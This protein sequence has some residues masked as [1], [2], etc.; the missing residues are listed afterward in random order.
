MGRCARQVVK[1]RRK[2]L[3]L[4]YSLLSGITVL[5]YEIIWARQ[6]ALVFGSTI[7]ATAIIIACF[8]AGIGLGSLYFGKKADKAVRSNRLLSN[9]QISI[10][11]F[12]LVSFLIFKYLFSI[13][14]FL[15]RVLPGNDAGYI[16]SILIALLCVLIPTLFMGGIL[17]ILSKL[18]ISD[19]HTVGKS[20]GLV[21]SINTLGSIIGALITGFLLIAL[22]GQQATVLTAVFINV[23]LGLHARLKDIASGISARDQT[24]SVLQK[25]HILVMVFAGFI[26]L[27]ALAYEILWTRSLNI[28]LANSTY[29]FTSM[30]IVFFIG[31]AI[32]SIIFVRYFAT[33]KTLI[34]VISVCQVIIG[35]YTIIIALYLN[36]LP[37]L[38]YAVK[39]LMNVLI[40]RL[41]LPG[42]LLAFFIGFIPTLCMGISF[43]ALCKLMT[44]NPD[45]AG[46]SIGTIFMFNTLGGV[47]G[48]L[49]AGF[50]LIPLIGVVKGLVLIAYMN[51]F[52]GLLLAIILHKTRKISVI[53][54]EAGLVLLS[55]LPAWRAFNDHMILPPSVFRTKTR[56]DKILFYEEN[57]QGT[58]MVIE[59]QYTRIRSCY[60]NN[61]AVCGTT[62]DALK[63]VKLLGHIPFFINPDA[64]NILVIG[65]GT[66]VTSGAVAMHDVTSIECV[67]ICAGVKNAARLFSEYN[68]NIVNDVRVCFINDDGRHY[69]SRTKHLYDIVSCD[70][71][72]P[73]LGCNNLYTREYFEACRG[74]LKPDGIIC[75]YLP[76]HKLSLPEFKSLISTFT[77]VFPHTTV[78]LAHSHGILL[79]T[80]KPVKIDFQELKDRMSRINDPILNDP[81]AIAASFVLDEDAV[82]DLVKDTR[83]NTDDHPILE[84]FSLQSLDQN[85]WYTNLSALYSRKCRPASIFENIDDPAK[86][87]RYLKGYS[88]FYSSLVYKQRGEI[89]QSLEALK[90]A[91]R[92]NPENREI[93]FFLEN[94]LTIFQKKNIP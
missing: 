93:R 7:T 39:G 41:V 23:M 24:P 42:T 87:Q 57:I 9:L 14:R 2:F 11:V 81:Y 50:L 20:I 83:I 52:I 15:D 75:Q 27:C 63:L 22:M 44:E 35:T 76:L 25:E 16:I 29:S 55:I 68:H 28:F 8:M 73:T 5:V 46:E 45:R 58:V 17:P 38:L 4:L 13:S 79:A 36:Q 10:A 1:T 69:V 90:Q 47:I 26:G 31:I 84:F 61:S 32:G 60:I 88:L 3:V 18:H 34:L 80:M 51:L 72:H 67:E 64:K 49:I 30:I 94:E 77:E 82:H 21:Y 92:V 62:Y 65:F 74:I 70:P 48:S 54:I 53:A 86:L 19:K 12:S 59:D 91:V 85:N 89:E 66:G 78:W 56:D 6:L 40:L 37:V 43:P 71:T 33:K